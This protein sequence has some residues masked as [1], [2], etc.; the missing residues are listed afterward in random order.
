MRNHFRPHAA[1]LGLLVTCSLLGCAG[2]S[3]YLV[4]DPPTLQEL[5]TLLVLPVN[6]DSTAAQQHITPALF[7]RGVRQLSKLVADYVESARHGTKPLGRKEVEPAWRS[8]VEEVGGIT[9]ASGRTLLE[10]PYEAA[11]VGLVRSLLAR[12]GGDGVL[13]TGLFVR[14]GRYNGQ[15]LRWDGALRKV[16]LKQSNNQAYI[17]NVSGGD[18]ATSVRIAVY[19][20]RGRKVFE[21]YGGL[22]PIREYRYVGGGVMEYSTGSMTSRNRTGLFQDEA[23]LRD[24]VRIAM[25]PLIVVPT[26]VKD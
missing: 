11:R 18:L 2:G 26:E 12:H 22:E 20:G 14:E 6:F 9:D 7:N 16:R 1:L 25:T 5:R 10:G 17:S 24:G 4:E 23:L 15:H 19:D 3:P 8:A 13:M 21:Q